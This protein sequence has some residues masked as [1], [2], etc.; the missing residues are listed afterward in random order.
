MLYNFEFVNDAGI[1]NVNNDV[2]DFFQKSIVRTRFSTSVMS[3]NLKQVVADSLMLESKFKEVFVEL[4]R[5]GINKAE[6]F[7]YLANNNNVIELLTNPNYPLLSLEKPLHNKL[8]NKI[9]NLYLFIWTSTF[10]TVACSKTYGSLN[11]HYSAHDTLNKKSR[12][13]CPFCGLFKLDDP[14]EKRNEYDH[15]LDKSTYPYLALNFNNLVPMCGK[16][17]KR[18]NKGTQ[19][20]IFDSK[21]NRRVAYY[22]YA[23]VKPFDMKLKCEN[24]FMP[25]E[26]WV[27]KS[28]SGSP[29]NGF[30][31]WK[32]VFKID[33]RYANYIKGEYSF[34]IDSFTTYYHGNLPTTVLEFKQKILSYIEDVL[35]IF[36]NDLGYIL[37]VKFWKYLVDI[38]DTD[39]ELVITLMDE[40]SKF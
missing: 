29:D 36:Q 25:D 10:N 16:C 38:Q 28:S 37:H 24:L 11:Q 18:P 3:D 35:K 8:I 39:L 1:Y 27:L 21:G 4:N 7:N 31:T 6:V 13:I 33:T 20:L 15:Y 19:N 26:R 32:T 30:K 22:P 14:L 40:K 5:S 12:R 9:R 2:L 34:W 17:N 23:A